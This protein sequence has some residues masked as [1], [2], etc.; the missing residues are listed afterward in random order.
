MSAVPPPPSPPSSPASPGRRAL[1][2]SADV[3]NGAVGELMTRLLGRNWRTSLSGLLVVVCGVVSVIPG[4]PPVVQDV[5]RVITPL[6]G[7]GALMLAKDGRVSGTDSA[8]AAAIHDLGE[9]DTGPVPAS[10]KGKP[11]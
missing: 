11:K 3:E 6:I 1:P 8:V 9:E 10:K 2:P 7:G 5:C 4:V